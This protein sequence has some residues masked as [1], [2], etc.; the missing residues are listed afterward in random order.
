MK[1]RLLLISIL[2]VSCFAFSQKKTNVDLTEKINSAAAKIEQKCIA[3]RRDIHQNPELGNYEYR[4]AKLI[5]D[6]LRSLGIEV[7]EGV[8]KTGVIGVLKG[9]K[10]EIGRASCRE[11]V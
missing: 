5:A 4:T 1:R 3:W 7:K 9:A 6:H 8:G 2:L 10:P 11:R